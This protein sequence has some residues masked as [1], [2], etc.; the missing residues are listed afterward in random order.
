MAS[1]D[2]YGPNV[3]DVSHLEWNIF[4]KYDIGI[5]K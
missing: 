2:F 1:Q 3:I 5:R 4:L